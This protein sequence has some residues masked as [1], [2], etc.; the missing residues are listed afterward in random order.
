MTISMYQASVPQFK[1]MLSNLSEILKKAETYSNQKKAN[2]K[3]LLES[4]LYIDMFALTKQIQIACYQAK[5]GLARLAGIEPPKADDHETSFAQLLER[6]SKTIAFLDSL[7]PE[8]LEGSDKKEIKFSI[9]EWKFEFIGDQYLFTWIIPNFY[10]H[11]TTAYNILRHNGVDIG[12]V[13][14][15]GR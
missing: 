1:K 9:G 11:I 7:K 10:F 3:V 8:Q 2:E 13:D 4:R 14:Y 12:K 5:N 6:I 15:L